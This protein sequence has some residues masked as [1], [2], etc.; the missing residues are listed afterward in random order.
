MN[1]VGIV[2]EY[3]PFHNGHQYQLEEAKRITNADA[4]VCIMS[5]SF[6]Q[7]GE[8]A[9]WDKWLRAKMAVLGGADLVIELPIVYACQSAE[10]FARGAIKQLNHMGCVTHLCFGSESGNVDLLKSIAVRTLDEPNSV[11]E[12]I[13]SLLA[14]GMVYPKA[15]QN[16][17]LNYF[18][19]N[20]HAQISEIREIL[21]SPNN[22]L[23]LEY[24]KALIASNSMIQPVT[25]K[26]LGSGYNEKTITTPLASATGIREEFRNFGLSDKLKLGIPS[27]TLS[28]IDENRILPSWDDYTDLLFYRIRTLDTQDFLELAYVTEGV[29]NRIKKFL[30]LSRTVT[31]LIEFVK[32]KRFTRTMIQRLFL[33]I[34]LGIKKTDL[35]TFREFSAETYLRVLAVGVNGGNVLKRMKKNEVPNI[36]TKFS[37]YHPDTDQLKRMHELDVRSTEVYTSIHRKD[38]IAAKGLTDYLVSPFV[39][40]KKGSKTK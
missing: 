37:N 25:I 15:Y 10:Y 17:Y 4:V 2:C 21:E 32:T 22:I 40:P 14:D 24:I 18:E 1:I 35:T 3:N 13:R 16:A 6:M 12:T 39:L 11:K 30:P 31:E 23:G 33:S 29:E 7:R 34:L 38:G 27:T 36:I 9:A 8:P 20:E 26:R 28:L 5:G 19:E